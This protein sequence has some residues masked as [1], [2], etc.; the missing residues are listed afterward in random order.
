[1]Q[2]LRDYLTKYFHF[3]KTGTGCRTTRMKSLTLWIFDL[4]IL[5]QDKVKINPLV[6]G[7]SRSQKIFLKA[8]VKN[9]AY[10]D[11][12][13]ERLNDLKNEFCGRFLF[14]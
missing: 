4:D 9:C 13:D 2:L 8:L 5:R 6:R 7:S 11:D 10:N 14:R 3:K 1:M 12:A